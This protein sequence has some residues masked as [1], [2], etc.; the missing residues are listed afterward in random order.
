MA[1]FSPSKRGLKVRLGV[2]GASCPITPAVR[3]SCSFVRVSPPPEARITQT[4]TKPHA[5][6]G[7]VARRSVATISPWD[8]G[9]SAVQSATPVCVGCFRSCMANDSACVARLLSDRGIN[10]D[11][12]VQARVVKGATTADVLSSDNGREDG[13]VILHL[14]GRFPDAPRNAGLRGCSASPCRRNAGD[15]AADC[16]SGCNSAAKQRAPTRYTLCDKPLSCVR[17]RST[18][19]GR[20]KS[21]TTSRARGVWPLAAPV[22][23]HD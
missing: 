1:I 18:A 7:R 19:P 3:W 11:A 10:S 6:H 13:D 16:Q 20:R 8:C 23:W 15:A 17:Q 9:A 5:A 4:T 21:G 22:R 14:D 12:S 2:G